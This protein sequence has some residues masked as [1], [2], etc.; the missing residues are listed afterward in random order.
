MNSQR[1]T[2][3]WV[4][5]AWRAARS[6][7]ARALM[8]STYRGA[9]APRSRARKYPAQIQS[10]RT[11]NQATTEVLSPKGA[12]APGTADGTISLALLTAACSSSE[13]NKLPAVLHQ[14]Q[15]RAADSETTRT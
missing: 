13:S 6:E 11:V 10:S 4:L 15:P 9:E 12:S 5:A 14:D 8:A 1:R 7:T 2:A 3:G